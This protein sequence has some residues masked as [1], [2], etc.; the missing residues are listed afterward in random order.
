YGISFTPE[1]MQQ[2]Y[3]QLLASGH[4]RVDSGVFEQHHTYIIA[5]PELRDRLDDIQA[6][7][8]IT[9]NDRFPEDHDDP[10]LLI[11]RPEDPISWFGDVV[12]VALKEQVIDLKVGQLRLCA[13]SSQS[14]PN[15]RKAFLD[16]VDMHVDLLQ[17]NR[18]NIPKVNTRLTDNRRVAYKLSNT[19]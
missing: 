14:L 16:A 13:T 11:L 3:D 5:S 15:A 8:A 1:K 19:F 7:M 12:S 17:E 6:I 10:Y 4:F 9:S 2:F 18:S